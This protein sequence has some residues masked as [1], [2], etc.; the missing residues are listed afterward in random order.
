MMVSPGAL[1]MAGL[2]ITPREMDF[3]NID[4]DKALNI[5]RECAIQPQDEME[6]LKNLK[7]IN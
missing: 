5:I 3:N 1:D 4:I 7:T 6:I 2:M